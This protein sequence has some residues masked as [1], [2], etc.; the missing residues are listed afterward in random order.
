MSL[1]RNAW[2]ILQAGAPLFDDRE[3]GSDCVR[4]LLRLPHGLL[5]YRQTRPLRG[6]RR[7]VYLATQ[8]IDARTR[9]DSRPVI[10]IRSVTARGQFL[11]GYFASV[12]AI[13][14]QGRPLELADLLIEGG[15]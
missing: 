2:V 12:D 14:D 8:L 5:H 4:K 13:N 3:I 1:I 15:G 11:V 9:Q 6:D 7:L 10:R